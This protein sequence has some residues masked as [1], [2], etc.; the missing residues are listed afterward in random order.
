MKTIAIVCL[1]AVAGAATVLS[2]TAQDTERP[3]PRGAGAR[4]GTNWEH[5]AMA[6][7]A[8]QPLS[9]PEFAKKINGLGKDGWER[10]TVANPQKEGTTVTTVYYF[11]RPLE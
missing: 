11:K 1:S 6:R 8:G 7:D 4:T 5:L 2:L 10:V 9:D 3:V